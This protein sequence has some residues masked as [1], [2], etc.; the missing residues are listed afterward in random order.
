[1]PGL[2]S[3]LPLGQISGIRLQIH[4]TFFIFLAW[5]VTAEIMQGSKVFEII[6]VTLFILSVFAC[7][8]L[9]ELGHALTAKRYGV[10]TRSITLLPFGGIAG[11][12]KIPEKPSHELMIALA[13]PAVN[14]VIAGVLIAVIP[15]TN[16]VYSP[17]LFGIFTSYNFLPS[18]ITA[19]ITLALFNLVPAFPMD[20]G[21]VLRAL[22]AFR[23]P[24]ITATRIASFA[25]QIIA[26]IFI[27]AGLFINPFLVLIG[28]FVFAGAGIEARI[29]E[30]TTALKGLKVKDVMLKKT[31]I[32]Q[33][34][35]TLQQAATRLLEVQ[36]REFIVMRGNRM[37]G[38]LSRE[39]ILKGFK[40][41]KPDTPLGEIMRKDFIP[42]HPDMAVE[43]A[44][45]LMEEHHTTVEPVFSKGMLTGIF[46]TENI[47]EFISIKNST[48]K[49]K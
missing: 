10:K 44:L 38:T 23:Y 29:T 28:I 26:I 20:G 19:N 30:T 8:I 33:E 5:V 18:L 4:W 6:N 13:G 41:K 32:L 1:M 39:D 47:A 31:P 25:G 43:D 3:S 49:E 42:L 22:L 27:I 35:E 45:K 34:S 7:I 21:R 9:H 48:L 24:R 2:T 46:E 17:N 11:M 15:L 14:L 16:Q 12:E 37:A 40:S 36:E